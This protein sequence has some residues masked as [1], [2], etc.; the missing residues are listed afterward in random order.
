M[1][2][3]DAAESDTNKMNTA[4]GGKGGRNATVGDSR[5]DNFLEESP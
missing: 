5:P 4:R 3:K 2:N 1:L